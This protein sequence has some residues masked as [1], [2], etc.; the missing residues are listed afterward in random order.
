[1]ENPETHQPIL[2]GKHEL[3][4]KK[5]TVFHLLCPKCDKNID[6]TSVQNNTYIQCGSCENITWRPDYDPP[7]WAKTRNFILSLIGAI[8]IGIISTIVVAYI[9]PDKEEAKADSITEKPN[10]ENTSKTD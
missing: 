10:I 9:L 4:L 2:T 1:M 8:V 3:G 5:K 7:W 6:V